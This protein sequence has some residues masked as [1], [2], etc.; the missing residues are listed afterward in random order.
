MKNTIWLLFLSCFTIFLFSCQPK[1]NKDYTQQASDDKD[2]EVW[3][4]T[5]IY[6]VLIHNP[7]SLDEWQSHK[8][9]YLN[10][11]KMVNDIFNSVYAGKKTAYNYYT[12]EAMSIEDVNQLEETY[13]RTD[14]GK[15]Q[16]SEIWLY[17]QK[18]AHLK[19]EI[20]SILVAYTLYDSSNKI[21]GYKA[22]FY[23]KN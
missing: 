7:D 12:N 8:I 4:D 22:A 3:A 18:N 15:L 11:K 2:Y 5:I 14:I 6:E 13:K 20:H 23:L 16:F 10:H 21:R 9:K 17:N 19:K 1:T